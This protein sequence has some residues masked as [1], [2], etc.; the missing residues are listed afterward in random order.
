MR[1]SVIRRR[2][3]WRGLRCDYARLLQQV[4][5]CRNVTTAGSATLVINAG[6]PVAMWTFHDRRIPIH[7]CAIGLQIAAL[8]KDM[9]KREDFHPQVV[10]EL[11]AG[12]NNSDTAANTASTSAKPP[13]YCTACP[14]FGHIFSSG[15]RTRCATPPDMKSCFRPPVPLMNQN[16]SQQRCP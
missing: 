1:R 7:V 4:L 10:S 8:R 12:L 16:A 5:R 11:G 13:T 3:G 9:V 15:D 14:D 6:L 2:A